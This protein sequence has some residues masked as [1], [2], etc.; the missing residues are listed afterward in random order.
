MALPLRCSDPRDRLFAILD[1]I[2]WPKGA[3][4]IRPDYAKTSFQVV[5]E[6][7]RLAETVWLRH[8]V[9][10]Y[11][12]HIFVAFSLKRQEPEVAAMLESRTSRSSRST[13]SSPVLCSGDTGSTAKLVK[14]FN[15]GSRDCEIGLDQDGR[16][17]VPVTL[18]GDAKSPTT[19]INEWL[20]KGLLVAS[21][22]FKPLYSNKYEDLL[23][24][25]VTGTTQSGDIIVDMSQN[26]HNIFL[27]LRSHGPTS[28]VVG[29]GVFLPFIFN[30]L[31]D[32]KMVNN[33]FEWHEGCGSL[34]ELYLDESGLWTFAALSMFPLSP[35]CSVKDY[36][37]ALR[38]ASDCFC[39]GTLS[40]FG[41]KV[42][43]PTGLAQEI[44][45]AFGAVL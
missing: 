34:H 7:L 28:Y 6:A 41:V 36:F 16:L 4:K 1:L 40:S 24:A 45:K 42:K 14:A 26:S 32:G 22:G 27:V 2:Y 39:C 3:Q 19:T 29:V 43:K 30:N 37:G 8:S 25:F 21:S 13:N 44:S 35:S 20:T 5:R 11:A 18:V 23:V 31:S 10:E 9:L 12:R 33:I 15:R 17:T 38:S